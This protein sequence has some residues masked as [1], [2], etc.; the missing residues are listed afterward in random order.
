MMPT[1]QLSVIGSGR[2]PLHREELEAARSAYP[3]QAAIKIEDSRPISRLD[4]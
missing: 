3:G 2:A 4:T 1:A